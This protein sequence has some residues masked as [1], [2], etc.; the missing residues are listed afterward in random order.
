MNAHKPS[1]AKTQVQQDME[2]LSTHRLNRRKMLGWLGTAGATSL[3]GAGYFA[4]QAQAQPGMGGFGGRGPGGGRAGGPGMFGQSAPIITAEGPDGQCMNF[5][6]ET[7]GPYPADGTVRSRNGVLNALT[8][9]GIVRQNILSDLDDPDQVAEGI[10]LDLELQ[11]ADV[12]NQCQP[13]SGYAVYLWHCDALGRYSL[14]SLPDCSYLRGVQVSDNQGVVRFTTIFPGCY[15]GR[16]PHIHFEVFSSLDNATSAN[17]AVLISQL[18]LSQSSCQEVYQTA[19]YR[20]S[21][22]NFA[23]N[24]NPATDGIFGNNGTERIP[25]MTLTGTGNPQQ[26]YRMGATIGIAT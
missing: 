21:K 2:K 11:L 23:R 20:D 24:G 25:V 9:S 10:L 16:Y 6:T 17:H 1:T 8:D 4:S 15:S 19:F 12:N 14:Y 5:T 26:G 3:V 18:A 7:N 22:N 13:L